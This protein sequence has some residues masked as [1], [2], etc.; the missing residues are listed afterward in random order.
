MPGNAVDRKLRTFMPDWDQPVRH[1]FFG[2]TSGRSSM[3]TVP[4]KGREDVRWD[5]GPPGIKKAENSL[6]RVPSRI[7]L[8][9]RIPSTPLYRLYLTAL[10]M[11]SGTSDR[12]RATGH[13]S[14]SE[15]VFRDNYWFP[16]PLRSFPAC[17]SR[18][19]RNQF[20]ARFSRAADCVGRF[21]TGIS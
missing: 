16:A 17:Y 8:W 10:D 15:K 3:T 5:I 11:H 14:T 4:D 7:Y 18:Q 12:S 1:F 2:C 9:R 6:D 21:G 20:P 13:L 19:E